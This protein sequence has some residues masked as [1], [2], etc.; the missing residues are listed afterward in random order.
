MKLLDGVYH[1]T[2]T[3][4]CKKQNYPFDKQWAFT[5]TSLAKLQDY[6]IVDTLERNARDPIRKLGPNDRL[7][8][9]ARLCLE[10][11]IKPESLSVSIAAAIY[12]HSPSD[13]IAVQLEQMRKEKGVDYVLENVCQI[14]PQGELATMVKEKI[15]MLKEKGY[16]HD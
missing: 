8:G 11:G 7:V 1:E 15:E 5:R 9:S 6:N 16:I 13:P 4:L 2:A 14:D 10:E 12:Y 3:A